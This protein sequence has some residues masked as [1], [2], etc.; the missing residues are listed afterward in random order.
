MPPVIRVPDEIY[1]RLEQYAKGFDTPANVIERLLNHVE[2]CG[3]VADVEDRRPAPTRPYQHPTAARSFNTRDAT[4]Y[5][6]NNQTFG[7]SRLVLAVV[8]DYVNRNPET[9]FEELQTVFPKHLQ[10]SMGVFDE[11]SDAQEIYERTGHKRHYINPNETIR[12]SDVEIAVCTQW[13]AGNIDKFIDEAESI[14]YEI[15]RVEN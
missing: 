12:L 11:I 13:G 14:G 8:Q 4:K 3:K 2:N 6:F 1:S 10:G 5:G 9:S 7:K 15:D